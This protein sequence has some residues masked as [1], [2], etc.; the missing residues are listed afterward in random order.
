MT[1]PNIII[2]NDQSNTL[3]HSHLDETYHS[4]HGAIQ[5]S[6]HVFIKNGLHQINA[7]QIQLLEVGFGTGL[8]CLLSLIEQKNKTHIHYTSLEPYPIQLETALN[9]NYPQL[10][11][12]NKKQ[13]YTL[14]QA[15]WNK[16]ERINNFFT[17]KKI[18]E[19]L[20]NTNLTENYFNLV[21]YDAFGPRAQSEMWTDTCFK[22]IKKAMQKNGILVTFC[23][24]GAVK[25]LLKELGFIVHT[26]PGPPGKREMIKAT[27]E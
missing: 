18:K 24:K 17:L 19:S 9:L 25:R 12:V 10:L 23:A 27:K 8:N 5:E 13:F 11:N 15:G 2:T 20:Q 26:L 1:E 22:I 21:Y 4:R 16:E 6:L 7:S 14:H 3:Y